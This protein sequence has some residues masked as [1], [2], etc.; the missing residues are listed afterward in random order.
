M[1]DISFISWDQLPTRVRPRVPIADFAPVLA[2]EVL[3]ESN[4][5]GEM[6]LK[7]KDYFLAGT[8]LVWLVDPEKRIVE[9]YTSPDEYITLTEDQTLDGGEV[10]PRFTLSLRKL[11]ANTPPEPPTAG[12]KKAPKRRRGKR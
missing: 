5:R 9:V 7:R 2:I 10:L 3:S 11:F 6:E 12:Q 8:Q 1:P 4:T